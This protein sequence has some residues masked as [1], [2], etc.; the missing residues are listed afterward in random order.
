MDCDGIGERREEG[1][2]RREE[3]FPTRPQ[4]VGGTVTGPS[5]T[6]L[7]IPH[8]MI[9]GTGERAEAQDRE[10]PQPAL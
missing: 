5:R 4:Q 8:S 1:G 6:V 2:G 7:V 10:D 3:V 9:E